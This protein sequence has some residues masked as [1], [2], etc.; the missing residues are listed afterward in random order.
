MSVYVRFGHIG[1]KHSDPIYCR[2]RIQAALL[3][4]NVAFVQGG[5]GQ[6]AATHHSWILSNKTSRISWETADKS[7]FVEVVRDSNPK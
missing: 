2:N 7:Y 6:E 4:A 1:G 3:A 5:F